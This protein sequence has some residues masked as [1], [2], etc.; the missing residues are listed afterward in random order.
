MIIYRLTKTKTPQSPPGF[1][2]VIGSYR[3]PSFTIQTLYFKDAV[4]ANSELKRLQEA[5]MT[6]GAQFD[7]SVSLDEVEVIE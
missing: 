5:I 7:Y 1:G 6:I 4:K 3:E 2:A